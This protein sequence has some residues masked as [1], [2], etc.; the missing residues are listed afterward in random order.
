MTAANHDKVGSH[1]VE[2]LDKV[3]SV[4][5]EPTKDRANLAEDALLAT[6]DEH[7]TTFLQALKRYPKACAWSGVVS[8]CIIMDGYDTALMGSLFAFPA[9]QQRYGHESSP[10][11]Y[12]LDPRWQM[13][14]G[15]I[16]GVGNI[17]GIWLN[18]TLTERFGHKKILIAAMIA[19]TGLIS[20][21]FTAPSVEQLFVGQI[22]C[23]VP[24]GMFTTLAPAFSSEVAPLVLRSYLETWIVCC[25]GI[26]QF[27]SFAVI[28]SL[29][30]RMDQWAYRIPFAV[31][32]VW[33]VLILPI[34]IFCP[35]SPWWLVRKGREEQALKSI[36]RLSSA[37][38]KEI[39][40]EKAKK[41]LALM[42]ETNNLEKDIDKGTSY[43][44]CFTGTDRRRTEIAAASWGIQVTSGFVI[45]GYATYWFQQAGLSPNDSF[46]MTL[47]IG[48]IH[49]VC[50]LASAAL[51]GNYGRRKLFLW[52]LAV[53]AALMFL[54]GFLALARQTAGFGYALSAI[55][56]LWF[57]IW[58]L[59]IGPLPYVINGEVSSTRLRSKT[60]A[61][62][63]GTYLILGVINSTVSPYILN[64]DAGDWKGRTGLLTGGLTVLSL[65]W[66]WFRLPETGGRTFEE[67]DILFTEK[68]LSAR[69]FSK[70]V[71]HR[72]G[73]TVRVS[74]PHVR[75]GEYHIRATT[76]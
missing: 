57:G 69:N 7:N 29:N 28:F 5:S 61:I 60:I 70:A 51:S 25:W 24:W 55:Y 48:G 66:A 54:I 38:N 1:H 27:F 52:G 53:L 10:G 8:L 65:A 11:K 13:A 42:I 35:E 30:T 17:F 46:K 9:F 76:A 40:Q 23:G 44:S 26:G 71:I 43:W 64:P 49:L 21:Q 18:A 45:Q 62:A 68:N 31:Q 33:P 73:T 39:A 22:L 14:L 36:M 32:W 58:C 6:E 20:I 67:L 50:N 37:Q 3:D 4:S 59:T 12:Q 15:M 47:G 41:A 74:G 16:T 19:L 75:E 34:V 56:L 72:E 2:S 63:R